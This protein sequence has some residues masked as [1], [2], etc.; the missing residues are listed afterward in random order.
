MLNSGVATYAGANGPWLYEHNG[1]RVYC[2]YGRGL[3]KLMADLEHCLWATGPSSSGLTRMRLPLESHRVPGPEHTA[4][5]TISSTRSLWGEVGFY[6]TEE[7]ILFS[8]TSWC[9]SRECSSQALGLVVLRQNGW[10][11]VCILVW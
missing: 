3:Y 5:S 7:N 2:R 8:L 1:G 6:C 10:V 11:C 4:W 9:L